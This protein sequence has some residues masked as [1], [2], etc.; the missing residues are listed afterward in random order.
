MLEAA[1]FGAYFNVMINLK[2]ITDEKFKLAVSLGCASASTLVGGVRWDRD[3]GE[4]PGTPHAQ[5][6]PPLAA[7]RM[8]GVGGG[9]LFCLVK[10]QMMHLLPPH[11]DVAEGLRDAGGGEARLCTC[12]VTAGEASTL[13]GSQGWTG[14]SGVANTAGKHAHPSWAPLLSASGDLLHSGRSQSHVPS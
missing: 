13:R 14:V 2:D 3:R 6:P 5:V 7:N 9:Q 4:A 1:V 8:H 11:A 12:A 10:R